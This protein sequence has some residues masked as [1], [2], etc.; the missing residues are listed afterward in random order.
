MP[1]NLGRISNS[2][3]SAFFPWAHQ[4]P[5][6]GIPLIWLR[7][8]SVCP[9]RLLTTIPDHI[10]SFCGGSG[11]DLSQ[12]GTWKSV[13]STCV[14]FCFN[15]FYLLSWIP[16]FYFNWKIVSSMEKMKEKKMLKHSD[17]PTS[18]CQMALY[19]LPQAILLFVSYFHC[20]IT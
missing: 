20:P 16:V 1:C 2:S 19:H 18:I 9:W 12:A 11:Y 3:E 14:P 6:S 4:P 10:C 8:L 5:E 13:K 15:S 17:F 7:A